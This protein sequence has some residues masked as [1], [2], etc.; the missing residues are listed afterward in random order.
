MMTA[1]DGQEYGLIYFMPPAMLDFSAGSGTVSWDLSTLATSDRDWVDVWITPYAEQVAAPFEREEDLDVDL[2]GTPR[3]GLQLRQENGTEWHVKWTADDVTTDL[4]TVEVPVPQ[5]AATRSPM[6]VTL[7]AD[8]VSFGF[9]GEN[10]TTF[11]LPSEASW[12]V[13]VVQFGHHSY[14][15]TKDCPPE[16]P[17]RPDSWHWDSVRIAPA[18][19]LS[20]QRATP[21]VIV[22]EGESP[23]GPQTVTW[24]GG[25]PAGAE[26]QFV[27]A[28]RPQVDVGAGWTDATVAPFQ[29]QGETGIRKRW[30]TARRTGP[31]CRR[32]RRPCASGSWTTTGT[33]PASAAS[34]RASRS[35][36]P[37]PP[38][39]THDPRYGAQPCWRRA[40]RATTR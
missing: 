21:E 28:C 30:S 4:G 17:C 26:L 25:A 1:I 23:T 31:P 18:V 12:D 22:A 29:G 15:P 3:N 11:D 40:G 36:R 7:T 38:H 34:P 27:A 14:N 24:A 8:T 35:P 6:E 10:V 5:S 39:R 9:T 37:S 16:S 19:P 32:V 20:I 2:Q 13:G 33:G